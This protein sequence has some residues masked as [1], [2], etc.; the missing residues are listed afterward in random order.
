VTTAR[1]SVR[2]VVVE[3][4]VEQRGHVVRALEADGDI[5]VVGQA[6]G[7]ADA[8]VLVA[9]LQPDVLALGVRG[10]A[11]A[12]HRVVEQMVVELA[13]PV[14]ALADTEVPRQSSN[15]G[16]FA[17]LMAGPGSWTSEHE[18]D[19]RKRVRALRGATIPPPVVGPEPQGVVAIAAS[20]GG[21]SALATVLSGLGGLR[22]PVLVVQH[23]HP[24]HVTRLV[25]LL[26]R[27][28]ALPIRPAVHGEPLAPGVAYVSPGDVHL[29][30][31]TRR[32]VAL[33]SQPAS[34]HRPSADQLF[35]SVARAAGAASVGVVLTGMG[36]DGVGGLTAIRAA[37]GLTLAQDEA[38][39]AVFGMPRAAQLA[40]AVTRVLAL[41]DLAR[42]IHGATNRRRS[43]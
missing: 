3:S 5:R 29:T 16:A 28:S 6:V 19:A 33:T 1:A 37:G 31:D 27:A 40:G 30:V 7:L 32:R 42:A 4:S 12:G 24:D 18:A 8:T 23:I 36:A 25:E 13:T 43:A 41:H 2:V 20:T 14:L 22:A 35:T 10:S 38:T 9:T 21:P 34:L 11:D 26:G 39:S 15:L 17:D